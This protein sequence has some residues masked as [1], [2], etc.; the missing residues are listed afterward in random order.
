MEMKMKINQM[1]CPP[2]LKNNPNKKLKELIYITIH[3]TG[4]TAANADA[5]SH[6]HYQANGSG[7]RQASWHYTVD[8]LE[9]W[10]S[11]PD[12]A[13]CWHTGTTVGNES[14]IG[15]EICDNSRSGFVKACENAAELTAHLLK[16]HNLPMKNVV[17]HNYWSG[18]DCPLEIR[19]GD[20]GVNWEGFFRISRSILR[21][22]SR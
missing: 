8:D 13:A 21:G 6:A 9:I 12:S 16:I 5:K 19:R 1:I 22:R 11:F 15:I 10:Q 17:Q 3:T 7:G 14:S 20:W 4:N 18:K 2:G